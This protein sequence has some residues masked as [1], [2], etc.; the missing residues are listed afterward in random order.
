MWA[1]RNDRL[2][3]GDRTMAEKMNRRQ[4]LQ[5]GVAMTVTAAVAGS[6]AGVPD[7]D[8]FPPKKIVMAK[9]ATYSPLTY[10]EKVKSEMTPRF[11]FKAQSRSEAETWRA[12]LRKELWGLLGESHVP[13][14]STP[15]GRKLETKPFDT[16]TQEKWEVDVVPGR[17]MPVYV[18]RPK[19]GLHVKKTVLCLHGHGNGARD[20][21]GQPVNAEAADLIRTIN[22][23]YALQ[24]VKKGWCAIAPDLFAFGQRV[25]S[26]EDARPGFDGGCEKPFLNAVQVGKTLIGIRAK[27]VC[28]LIDWLASRPDEFDLANL[29]CVGLSG[30]GMMTMY[31][32]ALDDRIKRALIAGYVTEMSGSVLPIRHCSCNYVPRLAQ[33]AD[34]PDVAGLIAPRFLIVQSGR[35]DGIFP[36]ASVR[37]AFKKIETVYSVY[38]SPG[39]VKLHEHD[40]FHSFWTPSLDDFLV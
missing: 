36:I 31:V 19:S 24:V 35:K 32:T 11:A 39:V 20:I 27:D 12:T 15:Q 10:L 23:D 28:V 17:S 26:V 14:A 6:A 1:F 16:Y 33:Y 38:G 21:I 22:T 37:A 2:H 5:G 25:D 30:G 29:G 40:G 34:F 7:K 13:G 8:P 3:D 18:L 9:P 4:V